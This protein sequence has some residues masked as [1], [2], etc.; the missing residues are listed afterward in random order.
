MGR[1]DRFAIDGANCPGDGKFDEAAIIGEAGREFEALAAGSYDFNCQ[2][3][4]W[5]FDLGTENGGI[6]CARDFNVFEA[7]RLGGEGRQLSR[8]GMG[9]QEKRH[10]RRG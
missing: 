5:A 9:A 7:G 3:M 1:V 2:V 8:Y 10:R 4:A 6:R